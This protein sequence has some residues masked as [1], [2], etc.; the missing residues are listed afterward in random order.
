MNPYLTNNPSDKIIEQN[1]PALNYLMVRDQLADN[2]DINLSYQ[3]LESSSY[4]QKIKKFS[5]KDILG[6]G[7]PILSMTKGTYWLFCYFVSLGFDVRNKIIRN[8]GEWLIEKKMKDDG[9]FCFLSGIN[10]GVG[11]HT[12][13]LVYYMLLAGFDLKYLDKSLNW[14]SN[15][16]RHDGGWLDCPIHTSGNYYK[17]FLINKASFKNYNNDD[18]E[19]SSCI[20]ATYSCAR[21][22]YLSGKKDNKNG[23]TSAAEYFLRHRLCCSSGGTILKPHYNWNKDFRLLGFP[24]I[25]QYDILGGLEIINNAGMLDDQ[26]AN[27]AFNNVVSSQQSDGLFSYENY[28]TGMLFDHKWKSKSNDAWISYRVIKFLNNLNYQK[29][30]QQKK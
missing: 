9:S 5:Q 15:H 30:N 7:E 4:S 12:G 24:V 23:L 21:A 11:C 6:F 16:Q 13:D 1:D 19:K 28:G 22:L 14:L 25:N 10:Q 29:H 26:R 18:K 20:Y 17:Y 2:I 3:F 8:T 27:A